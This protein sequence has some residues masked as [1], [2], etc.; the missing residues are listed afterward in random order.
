MYQADDIDSHG[1][2]YTLIDSD[3]DS[4]GEVE[5]ASFVACLAFPSLVAI[6]EASHRPCL[7]GIGPVEV[8]VGVGVCWQVVQMER[9]V[10]AAVADLS[11]AVEQTVREEEEEGQ[12]DTRD[13]DC[14]SSDRLI[15]S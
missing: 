1:L 6:L 2:R 4:M 15:P 9:V 3:W 14:P 8:Q 5:A 7:V 10:V 13:V 11:N 12:E